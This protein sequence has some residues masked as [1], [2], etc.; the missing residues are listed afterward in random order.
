MQVSLFARN[1]LYELKFKCD[2]C[3]AVVKY[4]DYKEHI[5]AMCDSYQLQC[6]YMCNRTYPE[7]PKIFSKQE[8]A[9]H[10]AY[11]CPLVPLKC[12]TC[13]GQVARVDIP[14]HDCMTYLKQKN[15][16]LQK[17]ITESSAR[18]KHLEQKVSDLE[19]RLRTYEDEH[20]LD[21]KC[22]NGHDLLRFN[23]GMKPSK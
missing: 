18:E 15:Q 14:K 22:N 2:Y 16:D 17:R 9:E 10:L 4:A 8:L 11:L 7:Q 19:E 5:I 13:D 1:Q 3:T 23:R 6:P 12:F 21:F 20:L